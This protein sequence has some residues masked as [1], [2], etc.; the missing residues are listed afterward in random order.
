MAG[1]ESPGNDGL[2]KEFYPCFF[3]LLGRPL[4]E[5]L[6][7]TFDEGNYTDEAVILLNFI[8]TGPPRLPNHAKFNPNQY[9][10]GGGGALWPPTVF[11]NMSRMI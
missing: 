10:R 4:L 5:S 11:F 7:V 2:S 6:N 9:G 8:F 1:N 3:D